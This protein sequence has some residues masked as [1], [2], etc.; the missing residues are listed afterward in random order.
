MHARV[1]RVSIKQLGCIISLVDASDVTTSPSQ[2]VAGAP[3]SK[4]QALS[5]LTFYL[6]FS[7]L[8]PGLIEVQYVLLAC[9]RSGVGRSGECKERET[10]QSGSFKK[11]DVSCYQGLEQNSPLSV[12]L[13]MPALPERGAH[14]HHPPALGS[15]NP[16]LLSP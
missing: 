1:V 10:Q 12:C 11:R 3:W 9:S 7:F 4:T 8:F 13:S 14:H 5:S 15:L 2:N 6:C 16:P